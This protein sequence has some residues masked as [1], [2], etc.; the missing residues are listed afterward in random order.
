MPLFSRFKNKGAQPTSK[1]KNLGSSGARDLAAPRQSQ[2]QARWESIAIVPDEVKELVHVCTMEM[3]SR[4]RP[5]VCHWKA[6]CD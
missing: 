4:G 1:G 3:K 2:W 5:L 6:T